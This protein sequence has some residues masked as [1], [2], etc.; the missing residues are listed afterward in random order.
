M[1]KGGLQP[2][3][4]PV[5]LPGC[6]VGTELADALGLDVGDAVNLIDPEGD[7]GPTG[8]IPRSRPFRVVAIFYTGTWVHGALLRF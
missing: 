3:A 5:S 1:E 4:P 6:A 8:F 2:S 7:I